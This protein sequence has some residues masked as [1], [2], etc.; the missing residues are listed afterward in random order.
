MAPVAKMLAKAHSSFRVILGAYIGSNAGVA[1]T[2]KQEGKKK[3][4][5]NRL[6]SSTARSTVAQ[7]P[8]SNLRQ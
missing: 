2:G 3:K 5:K 6:N 8:G 7:T 1:R 4:G